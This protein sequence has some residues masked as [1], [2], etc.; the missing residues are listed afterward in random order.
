VP[1]LSGEG[2]RFLRADKVTGREHATA[3]GFDERAA[4]LA[5]G[6]IERCGG[7]GVKRGLALAGVDIGDDRWLWK[8]RTGNAEPHHPDTAEA[9]EQRRAAGTGIDFRDRVGLFSQNLMRPLALPFAG[10]VF[11]T[12]LLFSLL[13]PGYSVQASNAF[14]VPTVLTTEASV[15]KSAPMAAY[16]TDDVIVDVTVDG[17]GRMTDYV[18]VSGNAT[19]D[20]SLR[21]RIGAVLLL[22]EFNPATTL[23]TPVAGSVRLSFSAIHSRIDVKG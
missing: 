7:A 20:E 12:V 9:D 23:G 2:E 14:D 5:V 8:Q 10:G 15:R 6:R 16:N 3:G 17:Q 19:K 18:I 4:R 13:G 22:T 11:S 21:R 1:F